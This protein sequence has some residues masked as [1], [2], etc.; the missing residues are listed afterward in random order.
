M[1]RN[2]K[3]KGHGGQKSGPALV[4]LP[5]RRRQCLPNNIA[6]VVVYCLLG[7]RPVEQEIDFRKLSLL[8]FTI[9]SENTIESE[10]A[11]RQMAVKDS[12]GKSWF[13]H[14]N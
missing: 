1:S 14:C 6:N 2:E 9:Y 8:I 12:D 7:V 3:K 11:K 4:V 10:L 13:I 5:D